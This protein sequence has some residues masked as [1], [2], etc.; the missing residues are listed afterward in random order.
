[1]VYKIVICYGE[2]CEFLRGVKLLK[3]YLLLSWIHILNCRLK[4]KGHQCSFGNLEMFLCSWR[5]AEALKITKKLLVDESKT[6]PELQVEQEGP[7]MQLWQFGKLAE[8]P[9][10]SLIALKFLKINCKHFEEKQLMQGGPVE[11]FLEVFLIH[12]WC[13]LRKKKMIFLI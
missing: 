6:N 11:Q 8:W 5:I 1:M 3:N 10:V 7:S 9:T 13:L 12:N 4:R 2:C